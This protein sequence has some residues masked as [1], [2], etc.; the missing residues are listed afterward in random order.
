MHAWSGFS[1]LARIEEQVVNSAGELLAIYPGVDGLGNLRRELNL[2]AFGVQA[3]RL[4]GAL[5]QCI[6]LLPAQVEHLTGLAESS[7]DSIRS[8]MLCTASCTSRCNSA[9]SSAPVFGRL[10]NSALA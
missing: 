2:A 5:D 9:L 10:M 7:S 6:D 1:R 4:R 3:H 8:V